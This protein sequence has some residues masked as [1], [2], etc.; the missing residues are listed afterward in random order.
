[1][2]PLAGDCWM[3]VCRRCGD[4][5]D[6]WLAS[7]TDRVGYCSRMCQMKDG[8]IAGYMPGI[9]ET[10]EEARRFVENRFKLK[11]KKRK[12][13]K[14]QKRQA[15]KIVREQKKKRIEESRSKSLEFFESN[16]WRQLRYKVLV[17][18]GRKCMCCGQSAPKVEIHVDHIK[19]RYH[20]PE[21]ALVESNLQVL[22][23]E[24][25]LGKGAKFEH[26]FR[27]PKK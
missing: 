18:H 6:S 13:N 4:R 11:E 10:K 15:D 22:C 9:R 25:N 27:Q 21:L 19:P 17:K 5:F 23:K 8:K 3:N 14:S 2:G 16:E 7:K 20:H 24:C 12:L 1:M 26:D